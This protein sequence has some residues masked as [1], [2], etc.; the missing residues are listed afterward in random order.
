MHKQYVDTHFIR[1]YT[2]NL[3]CEG[4]NSIQC[5]WFRPCLHTNSKHL[6]HQLLPLITSTSQSS[7][8]ALQTNQ[9]NSKF[10]ISILVNFCMT[11]QT[12]TQRGWANW[13]LKTLGQQ[14]PLTSL[15]LPSSGSTWFFHAIRCEI[16]FQ[17]PEV[18]AKKFPLPIMQH[19]Y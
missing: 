15:S 5:Q 16:I 6:F 7:I 3:G 14:E 19:F 9:A 4:F 2:E 11:A 18:L 8:Q 10:A 17:P 1:N 12:D 13:Q